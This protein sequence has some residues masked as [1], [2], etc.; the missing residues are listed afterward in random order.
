MSGSRVKGARRTLQGRRSKSLDAPSWLWNGIVDLT[1][2][3]ESAY[4]EHCR[5]LLT[6]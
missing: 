2:I 4:L 5:R 3:H 6:A 1:G